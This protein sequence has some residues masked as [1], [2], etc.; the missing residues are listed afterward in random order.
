MHFIKHIKFI[1]QM[2]HM[3][4]SRYCICS[5]SELSKILICSILL[6]EKLLCIFNLA[7]ANF[8]H[9]RSREFYSK[10]HTSIDCVFF[11]LFNCYIF[12]VIFYVHLSSSQ[13]SHLD[14]IMW[15]FKRNTFYD[16]DFTSFFSFW[17]KCALLC[18]KEKRMERMINEKR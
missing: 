11:S 14:C 15:L 9:F 1:L 12:A 5:C 13:W 18:N 6:F 2:K 10:K 8:F 17:K 4:Y 3:V 16:C 7:F